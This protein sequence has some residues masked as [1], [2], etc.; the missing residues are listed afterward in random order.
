MNIIYLLFLSLIRSALA[1]KVEDL[2]DRTPL[3]EYVNKVEKAY[4]WEKQETFHSPIFGS[5]IHVLNVTS[6]E[7][8]DTTRAAGVNGALW[9]HLV[10]VAVP[11]KLTYTN[12]SFA[13]ITGGDNKK[14]N[15]VPGWTDQ[16]VLEVDQ[17]AHYSESVVIAILQ[18]PNAPIV[19]PTDPEQKQR[20]EDAILAW[21]WKEF[22]DDPKHDPE[23]LARLPMVKAAF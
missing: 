12:V 1:A 19:F 8:L 9:T 20:T 15:V 11:R 6:L 23:W 17:L 5:M 2:S 3:D 21:A 7:W 13:Y 14:P 18:I 16:D 10:Y 22:L 4:K